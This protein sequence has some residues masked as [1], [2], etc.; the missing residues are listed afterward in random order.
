MARNTLAI[1]MD[2][3]T[4]ADIIDMHSKRL[5][6]LIN[7]NVDIL[8]IETMRSLAEV[9]MILRFL[10]SRNVNVKVLDLFQSTGKLREEEVE[11]DPSR[12][13]YGD[14]VTDAFQTVSKYSNVFGFGTNCVNRKKCE[15]ISEVSSQAKAEAASDIRLIVYP[16][17]GQTW[18]SDKGK[19]QKQC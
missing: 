1:Y 17:V 18:I 4:E 14:Y 19:T 5:E 7:S 8:A 10:Q 11:N 13:A 9:E 3:V 6:V 15:Y 16:N 12:T 2:K